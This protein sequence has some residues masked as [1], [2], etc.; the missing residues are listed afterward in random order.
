MVD[1]N[2]LH[3]KNINGINNF[4]QNFLFYNVYGTVNIGKGRSKDEGKE[5]RVSPDKMSII[6]R[7]SFIKRYIGKSL[8]VIVK[9]D[10]S[11]FKV[12]I[13]LHV[14][15]QYIRMHKK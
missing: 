3:S 5:R 7:N 12:Q 8:Y 1:L 15:F 4:R 14:K 13:H 9:S 11:K 6:H 10:I 2:C